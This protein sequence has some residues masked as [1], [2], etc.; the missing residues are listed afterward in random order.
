V[1]SSIAASDGLA[2]N[3]NGDSGGG[4]S[5]ACRSMLHLIPPQWWIRKG[6]SDKTI[7]YSDS[8]HPDMI[9][10]SDDVQMSD[11]VKMIFKNSVS[12]FQEQIENETVSI[13]GKSEIL[14]VPPRLT[15]WLTSVGDIGNVE[16]ERRCLRIGLN[17]NEQRLKTISD[18]L[19]KRRQ[20]GE[21]K[22]PE[23]YP[24]VKICRA[25]FK[26]LKSKKEK[27]VFNFNIKFKDGLSTDM[28]NMIFELLLTTALI[29]KYQRQRDDDGAILATKEDFKNVIDN[30][31]AI[32]DTQVSQLT[33]QELMAAMCQKQMGSEVSGNAIPEASKKNK[34]WGTLVMNG[35]NGD[36]MLLGKMPN[37]VEPAIYEKIAEIID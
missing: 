17:I 37:V 12:D 9:F 36:Y 10:L 23:D 31:A 21:E 2:I 25:I 32:T 8:I 19:Q 5:H 34:E 4:K 1:C 24:E 13:Q 30:F 3:F 22:Y 35:R 6:L 33:K 11:D 14:K 16:V 27:V 20:K 26:E 7:F 18:R 29:N 15:W 28:Q